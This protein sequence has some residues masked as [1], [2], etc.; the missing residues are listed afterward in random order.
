M[1]FSSTLIGNR[2]R[3]RRALAASQALNGSIGYSMWYLCTFLGREC[4]SAANCSLG[5]GV[6]GQVVG[7]V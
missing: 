4:I 2:V 5:V 3:S 6:F 7:K 1:E